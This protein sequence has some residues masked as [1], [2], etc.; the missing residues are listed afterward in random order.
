MA[1]SE[2]T[3]REQLTAI[4]TAEGRLTPSAVVDSAR[5]P[6]SPLHPLF[7]WNDASAAEAHRLDTARGLIRRVVVTVEIEDEVIV[8]PVYVH[9]PIL[10]P[11]VEGY[12][13]VEIIARSESDSIALLK[14]EIARAQGLVARARDLATVVK[15]QRRLATVVRELAALKAE[16]DEASAA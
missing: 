9:D 5:N 14:Q 15:W 4:E 13:R 1:V 12:R 3:I 2:D 6:D 8:H 7:D 16:L 10:P 11:K